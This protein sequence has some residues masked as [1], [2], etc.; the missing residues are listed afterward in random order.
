VTNFSNRLKTR[1]KVI[2]AFQFSEELE[3]R[4]KSQFSRTLKKSTLKS[5]LLLKKL[6]KKI[7]AV[8]KI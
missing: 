6:S 4:K 3:R 7:E 2:Q 5:G 8:M 1:Q